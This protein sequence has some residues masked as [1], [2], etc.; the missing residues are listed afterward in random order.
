MPSA[1]LPG[2]VENEATEK[3]ASPRRSVPVALPPSPFASF[4]MASCV[5]KN[6]AIPAS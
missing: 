2:E 1:C 4:R 6:V 3:W 5:G